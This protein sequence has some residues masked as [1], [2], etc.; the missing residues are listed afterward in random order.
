MF[1]EMLRAARGWL[2]GRD[3]EEIARNA[4]VCFD[5]SAFCFE[6]FGLPVRIAYPSYAVSPE[7]D[8]WQELML[9]HYLHLADS[10]PLTGEKITFA[11]YKDGMIRG[12]GHDQKVENAVRQTLGR[13]SAEELR[14]RCAQLGAR[15]AASNA[16]FCVEIPAL[17]MYPVTLKI[18]FADE[19]F[20]ASGRMLVDSSA[21]HYLTIEDAVMLVELILERLGA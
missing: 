9:L 19:E 11:Q 5:G 10:A 8:P 1:S 15:E 21:P 20:D 7:L 2:Q 4:A 13:L 18:W 12:G 17:P 6:S 14:R 16:D 3:A